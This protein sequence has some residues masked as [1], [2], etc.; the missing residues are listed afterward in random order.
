MAILLDGWILPIGG[1]SSERVCTCSLR[2][3]L[4]SH[5]ADSCTLTRS[6]V[7]HYLAPFS[8]TTTPEGLLDEAEGRPL[9]PVMV[10]A[11]RYW[12]TGTGL[13]VLAYWY[14]PTGTGL[15][16]LAHKYWPKDTGLQVLA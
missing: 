9:H 14:W 8:F 6:Q 15:Q 11:Y 16:E 13:Q 5:N 3:W 4:V 7:F 1:V 2:S 12:P 10:L